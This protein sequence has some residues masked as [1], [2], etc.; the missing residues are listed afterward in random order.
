MDKM[1]SMTTCRLC[2][3]DFVGRINSR[4]CNACKVVKCPVCGR[5]FEPSPAEFT[6]YVKQGWLTCSRKCGQAWRDSAHGRLGG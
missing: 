1:E 4:Y 6:R 5:E 2:G 3:R